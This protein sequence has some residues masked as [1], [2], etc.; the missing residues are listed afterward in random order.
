MQDIYSREKTKVKY[1]NCNF[2]KLFL[3]KPN[4]Y[5]RENGK[6]TQKPFESTQYIIA[7]NKCNQI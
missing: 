6:F 5:S 2:S 7:R 1:I 3:K 4:L